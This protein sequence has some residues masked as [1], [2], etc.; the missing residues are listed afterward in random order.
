VEAAEVVGELFKV[1]SSRNWREMRALYHPSAL[2]FTVTGGPAPLPAG[3]IIAEL[4]R[5]SKDIVY[6]VRSSPAVALDEHAAVV[7]GVMRR[8]LPEGGFEE[9]GHSWLLTTRDGL[10]YRQGVYHDFAS[11]SE[12]YARLGV[13]LGEPDPS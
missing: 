10:I 8:R 2:I 5:V 1:F 7:T 3:E 11:A 6:S 9:A 12:A 4:E 13:T